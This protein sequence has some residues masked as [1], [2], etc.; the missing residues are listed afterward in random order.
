M[1]FSVFQLSRLG[2][3]EKNEDRM[4]YCYT[5]EASIFL[6]A[7]GMGGHPE[8]EVAARLAVN[9]VAARFKEEA[10][11]SI[12]DP[13]A[14]LKEAL[15]AA[16]QE[17]KLYAMR[18][19]ATD[20][21]RTTL[22]AALIQDGQLSWIHCGDSRL[23]LVRRGALQTRTRDHSFAER[24]YLQSGD[25]GASLNRH[26]LYTC[27]GCPFVPEFDLA[28]PI[29]LLPGDKFLLCSD[30]LWDSLPEGDMVE[31]LANLPVAE[32]V[33]TLVEQ[34]LHNAGPEGDNVTALAL[35]W[36]TAAL[37]PAGTA[38]VFTDSMAHGV[39]AS[40]L[41]AKPAWAMTEE[42]DDAAIDRSI[43][44]INEVIRQAAARR[45]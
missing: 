38:T 4:G 8:G 6:L 21:P 24:P 10:E 14:F 26:V 2:G 33:P 35:E 28:G 12:S 34:A 32:A 29:V 5:R 27:L 37:E 18:T 3:R 44:E 41:H 7:D 43:A 40:T 15:L 1:K 23:Y 13:A 25:P 20:T 36:D 31:R 16:H 30:G 22:V 9:T 11:R 42:M 45:R 39:F 19:G 17:I